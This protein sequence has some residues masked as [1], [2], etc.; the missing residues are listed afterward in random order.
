MA[1]MNTRLRRPPNARMVQNFHLVWLDGSIDETNDDF[2]NSITKLRQVVNTVNT[3]VD[4]DECID[5]I[6]RYQRGESFHDLFL[7]H[8]KRT[9][10]QWFK[11][12]HQVVVPF[13]FFVRISASY[14]KWAKEWLKVAGVYTDIT[15]I[16]EA[17]KQAT[18]DCDH[19]SVS[20]SFAKK[21][22]GA[23]GSK[24]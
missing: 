7:V 20:I 21:T 17:L 13:I 10:Y 8:F 6:D 9:M 16:C 24:S 23:T 15:P 19:N 14:E 4:V 3:F 12:N 1:T 18:Q 2:R 22:D 11:I 5:F